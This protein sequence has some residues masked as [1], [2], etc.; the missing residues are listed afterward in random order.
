MSEAFASLTAILANMPRLTKPRVEFMSHVLHLFLCLRSRINFLMLARHTDHYVESTFRLHY[1]EFHDFTAMNTAYIQRHGSGHFVWA[2][3]ASYLPKSGTK[4]PGVGKYWSGCASKAL[5]GLELGL[6]SAIDVDYHTAFHVDAALTPGPQER[7]DKDIDLVDHY[8]QVVLW[9]ADKL[10]TISNYMAVDAYFGKRDFIDRITGKTALEIICLLRQDANLRYLYTGPKREGRGAPKRYDG[11]I[12]L[13][14][15][16]LTRFDLV[17]ESSTERIYSALVNCLFLKRTI[18][19]AYV[20]QLDVQG[21]VQ[22]YRP[23][24]STDL[25]LNA[26]QLVKYYRLRYQQEFLIRDGKQFTGLSDCQARSINKLEFHTNMAL[27][28]VNVAKVESG[29]TA[30]DTERKA[31]SM[32]NAKTRYHNELLLE[33]FISILPEEAKLQINQTQLRQLHSFGCIA[34]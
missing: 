34:A 16:D 14:K 33:R 26:V 25:S 19:L 27:S 7:Q 29:L 15:P 1:E 9:S 2:F 10:L 24:F 32:A 22:S 30:V 12:D 8:A 18:R 31:F 11:K 4:T 17:Q 28:V 20:Q 13:K 6:L 23:Y 3:D 5:V 21:E